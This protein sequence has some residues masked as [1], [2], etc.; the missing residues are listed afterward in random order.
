MGKSLR[1]ALAIRQYPLGTLLGTPVD[2]HS[3]ANIQSARRVAAT[4]CRASWRS[5]SRASVNISMRKNVISVTL[6]VALLF[7]SD[8]P[9]ELF[10]EQ[11]MRCFLSF[12]VTSP[13]SI[14]YTEGVK[15]QQK[16]NVAVLMGPVDE[17]RP[18]VNICTAWS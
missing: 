2:V 15:E 18:E 8:A 10:K 7:V 6:T 16:N 11:L 4:P 17:T 13:V 3:H 14:V 9:V 12:F 5:G 1:K